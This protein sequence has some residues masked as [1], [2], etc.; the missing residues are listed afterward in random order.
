MNAELPPATDGIVDT[1]GAGRFDQSGRTIS[2]THRGRRALVLVAR[3]AVSAA[4]LVVVFA[5]VTTA[6]LIDVWPESI[7]T[8]AGWLVAAVLVTSVAFVLAAVRWWEVAHT[9][10]LS[11]RFGVMLNDHLA[12]QF[13]SNFLPTTI[14][15]DVL[16]VKRIGRVTG[17][18]YRTFASVVI[19]RLTGWFVL[20]L[21]TLVALA[22]DPSLLTG[23]GGWGLLVTAIS[24]L[25]VLGAV[26]WGAEHP[27]GLGRVAGGTMM[28]DA[29]SAIHVGLL[30]YR[31]RP[32]VLVRLLLVGLFYQAL[33]VVAAILAAA[34]IGVRPGVVTMFAFIPI[35]LA[36]QVLPISI[37]GLGVREAVLVVLLSGRS[38]PVGEAVSVGLLMYSLTL[39]VSLVGAPALA[40][41]G[42]RKQASGSEVD[43]SRVD[44]SQA[45]VSQVER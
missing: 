4:L 34:S 7:G 44:G 39:V 23:S 25:L 3:L 42:R 41:G 6:E 1:A 37:G 8:A 30:S 15:G 17:D 19:E 27:R 11:C 40:L 12:G 2:Q 16:R 14:G 32:R 29:L 31:R 26:L 18:H 28:R 33:L 43:G 38:V 5:R 20:P 24:M 45:D 10:G 22:L 9:L 13:I 36:S 21:M 35:V